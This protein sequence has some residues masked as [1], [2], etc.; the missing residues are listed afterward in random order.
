MKTNNYEQALIIE[1]DYP[2]EDLEPFFDLQLKLTSLVEDS[3]LGIFDGNEIGIDT[4]DARYYIY[5]ADVKRIFEVIEPSLRSVA[6]MRGAVAYMR[7]G[8][9]D[10]PAQCLE[11][12]LDEMQSN[13][14][15]YR[16]E[17]VKSKI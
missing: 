13:P 12:R 4:T 6:F 9:P 2:H 5:G 11:V 7:L 17:Q 1:F 3:G 8:P 16:D 14:D 15:S 10:G